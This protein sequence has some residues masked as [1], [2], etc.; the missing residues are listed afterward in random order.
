MTLNAII[1]CVL[2]SIRSF[3]QFVLPESPPKSATAVTILLKWPI[4]LTLAE[5]FGVII[6][7]EV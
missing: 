5:T 7:Q 3:F 4:V 2:M 1:C 6:Y